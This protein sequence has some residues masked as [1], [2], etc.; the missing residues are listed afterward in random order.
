MAGALVEIWL[1]VSALSSLIILSL[2]IGHSDLRVARW[3]RPKAARL[4]KVTA[5]RRPALR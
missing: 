5:R 4:G 2:A 1:A 3:L